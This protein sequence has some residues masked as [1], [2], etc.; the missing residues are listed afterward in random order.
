MHERERRLHLLP[1]HTRSTAQMV[2]YWLWTGDKE[3]AAL[4]EDILAARDAACAVGETLDSLH[5]HPSYR[6]PSEP[7]I[8][9]KDYDEA[10]KIALELMPGV[11]HLELSLNHE[12]RL[13]PSSFRSASSY[14][15]STVPN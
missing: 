9:Q 5:I 15:R 11:S 4:R 13:F 10:L 14:S 8:S 2:A 6:K 7:Q 3:P 12:T 1:Q